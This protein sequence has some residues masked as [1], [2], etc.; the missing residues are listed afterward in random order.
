MKQGYD[1]LIEAK[2]H[3]TKCL[4]LISLELQDNPSDGINSMRSDLILIWEGLG[5]AV[6]KAWD[7]DEYEFTIEEYGESF[8]ENLDL[9][10]K[11]GVAQGRAEFMQ[12]LIDR[13]N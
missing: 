13:R 9:Y 12:E 6:E 3:L 4:D 5:S 11:A 2:E 10:Y 8:V 1:R 7:D